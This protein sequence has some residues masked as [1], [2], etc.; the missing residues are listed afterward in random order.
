VTGPGLIYC[1]V[2]GV[3]FLLFVAVIILAIKK[4]PAPVPAPREPI[5]YLT[6]ITQDESGLKVTGVLN[7]EGMKLVRQ[8]EMR[9]ISIGMTQDGKVLDTAAV[10]DPRPRKDRN[11]NVC[12]AEGCYGEACLENNR[13]GSRDSR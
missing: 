8:G 2:T 1:L 4:R 5:G 7:D 12:V 9:G 11:S 10:I 6:S 13:R 3:A